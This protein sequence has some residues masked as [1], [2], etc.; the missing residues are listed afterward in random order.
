MFVLPL[1][2]PTIS[3]SIEENL[4][5]QVSQLH[6]RKKPRSRDIYSRGMNRKDRSSTRESY[7]TKWS[8]RI[9]RSR[10]KDYSDQLIERQPRRRFVRWRRDASSARPFSLPL[11]PAPPTMATHMTPCAEIRAIRRG[12]I[13]RSISPPPSPPRSLDRGRLRARGAR[14]ER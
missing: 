5:R 10:S 12:Y 11:F 13:T 3:R 14:R 7:S 8:D 1:V 9:D 2:P 4:L 6:Q